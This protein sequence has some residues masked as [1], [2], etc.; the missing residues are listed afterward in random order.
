MILITHLDDEAFDMKKGAHSPLLVLIGVVMLLLSHAS[1]HG[2]GATAED[3]LDLARLD[4]LEPHL[5]ALINVIALG[6]VTHQDSHPVGVVIHSRGF[7]GA[8]QI[9]HIRAIFAFNNG[10]AGNSAPGLVVGA[11]T[12]FVDGVS[13]G[14]VQH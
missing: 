13:F 14:F 2:L 4:L 1:H 9:G 6:F 10:G 11:V 8:K 5:E 7:N 3:V 12:V